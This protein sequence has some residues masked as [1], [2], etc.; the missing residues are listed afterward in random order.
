MAERISNK[1][2]EL[3]LLAGSEALTVL[4]ELCERSTLDWQEEHEGSL[5]DRGLGE[6]LYTSHEF[7]HGIGVPIQTYPLFENALRY[8]QGFSIEKHMRSMGK[9]FENFSKTAASNPYSF[10]GTERSALELST[11]TDENRWISFPYPKWMNAR[12]SVNQGAAVLVTSVKKARELGVDPAKWIFLHGWVRRMKKSMLREDKLL[13]FPA[14]RINAQKAFD[15][16]G[17]K[18]RI[19]VILTSILASLRQFKLPAKNWD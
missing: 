19:L 9:L 17:I 7:A 14:I 1:D 16:A 11:V 12:D 3:V 15:M 6:T 5:E 10:Y 18:L 13:L 4:K 2:V 8:K